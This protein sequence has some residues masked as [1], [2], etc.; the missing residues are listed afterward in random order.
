MGSFQVFQIQMF[1]TLYSCD[2]SSPV[3]KVACYL[4]NLGVLGISEV[5]R[6]NER[7]C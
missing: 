6:T 1:E 5:A 7:F 4:A 2:V 3:A